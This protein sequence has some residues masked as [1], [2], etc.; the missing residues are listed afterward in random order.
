MIKCQNSCWEIYDNDEELIDTLIINQENGIDTEDRIENM[1]AY[2]NS[3][4]I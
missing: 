4:D 3:L 2:I 1:K